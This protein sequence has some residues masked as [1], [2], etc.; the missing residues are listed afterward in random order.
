[1]LAPKADNPWRF[2]FPNTADFN[3][4]YWKLLNDASRSA[5]AQA[6]TEGQQQRIAIIG[7]G[8]AG[9][10]AAREL[11]RSGYK[12]IDIYEATDR[13][14]G[15]TYSVPSSLP[16]GVTAFEM[17]AMRLPF[18]WPYDESL[19]PLGEGIGSE[20]CVLDYYCKEFGITTQRF[21]NPGAPGFKTGIYMNRGRGPAPK[22]YKRLKD[23]PKQELANLIIWDPKK[24]SD[25]PDP[26]LRGIYKKWNAFRKMFQKECQKV[27]S[28]ADKWAAFWHKV[29]SEYRELNFREL[30]RKPKA[31]GAKIPG[32]FGGLG[33]SP[34]EA[35]IFAVVGMGDGGWGAFYDI[36]ALYVLRIFLFGFS[37]GLQL[38]K[39][40]LN[41]D[42]Q[43]V[44]LSLK[45]PIDSLGQ[46]LPEPAF[47]GI[48]SLTDC[49]FYQPAT[50]CLRD[51][52]SL[53]EAMKRSRG[54]E[55][56]VQLYTRNGVRCVR[57]DQRR[58]YLRITS[59]RV[60]RDYNAVIVTALPWSLEVGAAFDNFQPKHLPLIVREAMN[61]SHFITSCK[62]FYPLKERYWE[63]SKIP[64]IIVTDTI[65]QGAY[66]IAVKQ[67]DMTYPG[68]VLISYTWEDDATKLVADKDDKLAQLCLDRLDSL[69]MRCKNVKQ[70]ISPYVHVEAPKVFHW[71]RSPS[72]RG[73]ARLYRQ[74]SW[75][76]DYALLTY[77]Q[78]YSAASGLYLAGEAYSVE[79]G[80]VEPALRSA[81]NAVV[82]LVRNTRGRFCN[83]DFSFKRDYPKFIA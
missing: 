8:V 66:G 55:D 56:G 63:K 37:D 44:D 76:L 48:Q 77:N 79:G 32:K 80:W 59:E 72:Y 22:E 73:C 38:I 4:N 41:D 26:T 70:I 15:R 83:N 42:R 24:S 12:N 61:S 3:F 7:A 39:G 58:R 6:S 47:L 1:M 18:F 43:Q 30:V 69:L 11:F 81:L 62:V 78:E 29:A 75:D 33:M 13:L 5:I 25:P 20:N 28:D 52:E 51:S 50:S 60:N 67:A 65:L 71:E 9:L 19:K 34:Q 27:Y 10:T 64:Q 46:S 82:H 23:V 35:R 36:S 68:I 2:K 16:D 53:Y 31:N 21:P 17:G 45:M 74:G 54:N 49:L 14:G 40:K 57:L